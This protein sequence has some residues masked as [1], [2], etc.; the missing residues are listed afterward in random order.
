LFRSKKSALLVVDFQQ[1]FLNKGK[2]STSLIEKN[3]RKAINL[4]LKERCPVYATLHYNVQSKR[5]PF[6]NFYGKVILKNSD[7]FEIASP[8][9]DFKDIEIFK[10]TKYSA[11]TSRKLL[12]KLKNER[13]KRLFLSGLY[14]E[15]CIL[16]TAIDG[17]QKNF[18]MVILKDCVIARV[19][20]LRT[21]TVEIIKNGFGKVAEIEDLIK[22]G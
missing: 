2:N 11:L 4:F 9:K 12:Q 10:K 20:E 19:D 7:G 18:E 1:Y 8:V 13:I 15:K 5:D 17:F 14:L 6:F 22:N 16:S 3:I 21:P